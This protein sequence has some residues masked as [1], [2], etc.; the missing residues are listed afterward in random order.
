LVSA[1]LDVDRLARDEIDEKAMLGLCG[2]VKI[3]RTIIN[4]ASH[5]NFDGFA[6]ASQ[7]KEFSTALSR[8]PSS[9]VA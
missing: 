9:E 4:G 7:W 5:V 3:S 6:P 1:G 2:I 8:T